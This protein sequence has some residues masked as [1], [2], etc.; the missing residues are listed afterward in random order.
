[1]LGTLVMAF[2]FPRGAWQ[3][4]QYLGPGPYLSAR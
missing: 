4:P 2:V 1:M 3:Q